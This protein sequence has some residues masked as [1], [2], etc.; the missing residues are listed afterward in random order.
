MCYLKVTK[1][2]YYHK[3]QVESLVSITFSNSQNLPKLH[4]ELIRTSL[5]NCTPNKKE[6]NHC[7][8]LTKLHLDPSPW[9]QISIPIKSIQ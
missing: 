6:L 7:S 3:L 2:V 4:Y 5:T 8:I 9:S 1:R